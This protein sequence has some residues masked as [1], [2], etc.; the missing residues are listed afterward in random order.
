MRVVCISDTHLNFL[1][2][3]VPDGDILIHAGDGTSRGTEPEVERLAGFFSILGARFDYMVFVPGNHDFGFQSNEFRCRALL[4]AVGV[5]VLIHES[6]TLGPFQV[7]GSPWTP[8]FHDWAFNMP[9]EGASTFAK[10]KWQSISDGTD[11]V[12]THGPPCGVL[13]AT[14]RGESV[15]CPELYHRVRKVKPK[16]HVFGHIHE[17]AGVRQE[18]GTTFV[19]AACLD[20]SYKPYT[21]KPFV[22]DLEMP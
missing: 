11:I 14:A 1:A 16:L 7:F 3:D 2:A 15:G 10:D 20:L 12:I 18:D 21:H 8:W 19:N 9:R 17:S 5:D 6:R 4:E 22:I 13:D